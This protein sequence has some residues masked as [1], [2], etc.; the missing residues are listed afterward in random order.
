[1]PQATPENPGLR[2][3]L[4]KVADEKLS[5]ASLADDRGQ[6]ILFEKTADR[7]EV[8]KRIEATAQALGGSVATSK[9][10]EGITVQIPLEAANRF[11]AI[12]LAKGKIISEPSRKGSRL[13]YQIRFE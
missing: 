9:E 3:L 5:P 10:G 8:L 2:A 11:Q 4:E 7:Q 12:E 13:I 6:V 1:M